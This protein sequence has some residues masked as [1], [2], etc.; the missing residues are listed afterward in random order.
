M[1]VASKAVLLVRQ[2]FNVGG[3]VLI[4]LKPL[5]QFLLGFGHGTPNAMPGAS[6]LAHVNA[7]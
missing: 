3:A 1:R 2:H 5:E 4:A 7:R 6:E